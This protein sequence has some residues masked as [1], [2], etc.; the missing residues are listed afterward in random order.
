[1]AALQR[2]Q[3]EREKDEERVKDQSESRLRKGTQWDFSSEQITVHLEHAASGVRDLSHVCLVWK[4][5]QKQA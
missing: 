5:G 2:G 4:S 1:M 3:I